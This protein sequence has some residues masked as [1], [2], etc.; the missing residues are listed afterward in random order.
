M[1]GIGNRKHIVKPGGVIVSGTKFQAVSGLD[2]SVFG[3]KDTA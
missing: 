2:P 1:G 3:N